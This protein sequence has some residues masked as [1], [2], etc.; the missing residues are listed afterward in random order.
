MDALVLAADIEPLLDPASAGVPEL[1]ANLD[2]TLARPDAA[3]VQLRMLCVADVVSNVPR[4]LLQLNAVRYLLVLDVEVGHGLK[5][6]RVVLLPLTIVV[7]FWR[8]E[9]ELLAILVLDPWYL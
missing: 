1:G 4:Y 3:Q 5:V 6:E 9:F 8:A 2:A 7:L